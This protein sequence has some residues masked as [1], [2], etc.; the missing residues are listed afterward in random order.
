MLNGWEAQTFQVPRRHGTLLSLLSCMTYQIVL[1]DTDIDVSLRH[2]AL[3]IAWLTHNPS[4]GQNFSFKLSLLGGAICKPRCVQLINNTG[5]CTWPCVDS[6]LF[7]SMMLSPCVL[8]PSPDPSTSLVGC[9]SECLTFWERLGLS[10]LASNKVD[11][12]HSHKPF[13]HSGANLGH[14]PSAAGTFWK[15]FRKSSGKTPE[16]LS[17]RFLKFP[18]RVRL[19]CP[20]PYNSR[21]LRLPEHFQNYLP[22]STAGGASFFRIGSGEGLPEPVMEFPAVLGV[23]LT[24]QQP[25]QKQTHSTVGTTRAMDL[26]M[27][28]LLQASLSHVQSRPQGHGR[29]KGIEAWQTFGTRKKFSKQPPSTQHIVCQGIHSKLGTTLDDGNSALVIGF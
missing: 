13:F 25:S 26:N 22:P 18:S 21:H 7:T 14:T 20:K 4:R 17:E 3:F 28:Q 24:I 15:K 6:M 27:R 11:V 8:S 9:G 2:C 10:H 19:G 5:A 16:T 1:P 23:V 29:R 12:D